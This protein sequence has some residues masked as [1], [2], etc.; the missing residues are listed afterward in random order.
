MFRK[1]HNCKQTP[2]LVSPSLHMKSTS[3]FYERVQKDVVYPRK[4]TTVVICIELCSVCHQTIIFC[5]PESQM[6]VHTV[7]IILS[8]VI[9]G[10]ELNVLKM[11]TFSKLFLTVCKSQMEYCCSDDQFFF[12]Q[13]SAVITALPDINTL[14]SAGFPACST[15][16]FY[17]RAI[18][19]CCSGCLECLRKFSLSYRAIM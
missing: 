18:R 16:V 15:A 6:F 5:K 7:K 8:H 4:A 19:F 11:E 9:S 2:D 10:K 12:F 17:H 1:R 14:D 3:P 13:G